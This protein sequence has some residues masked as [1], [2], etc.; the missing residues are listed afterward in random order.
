MAT[1]RH[2]SQPHVT[3]EA[4]VGGSVALSDWQPKLPLYSY[5]VS[6]P[7]FVYSVVMQQ[8]LKEAKETL[9]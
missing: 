8:L 3:V 2:H 1:P 6:G 9:C 5:T 4:P 7:V